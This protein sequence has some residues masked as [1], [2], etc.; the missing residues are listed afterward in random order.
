MPKLE[1]EQ[2]LEAAKNWFKETIA[3]NHIRNTKLLCNP[4]EFK[5][6]PFLIKYLARFLTGN[7]DSISMAKAL[8]YPRV[9]GTSISTSFG[10]NIQ[11]FISTV[12]GAYGST[13]PGIDIEFIDQL[14]GRKKYCQLKLGPNNINSK[15]VHS[16]NLEFIKAKNLARTNNLRLEFGD[17]IVG[18]LYGE[19][20]QL[21]YNFK[22]LEKLHQFPVYIGKEFWERL[23]GSNSFY[24]ELSNAISTIAIEYD[25]S[26][27]L[28]ETILK[29]A[30]SI[31]I[32]KLD[33]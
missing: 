30:K 19:K 8:I 1:N 17:L 18:V 22:N 29:L 20:A 15:S 12:L 6:N 13:T 10:Q 31:E 7:S 24:S 25:S 3:K 21:T 14:D 23:T 28:D 11:K 9:L 33:N 26:Q 16:I 4:S 5:I 32:Q 2:I 27:L